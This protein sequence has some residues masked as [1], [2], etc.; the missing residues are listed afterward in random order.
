ML[1]TDFRGDCDQISWRLA[2][3]HGHQRY[4][5]PHVRAGCRCKAVR[6]HHKEFSSGCGYRDHRRAVGGAHCGIH[7][8]SNAYWRAGMRRRIADDG[9]S[10]VR[11]VG[12]RKGTL[13][14]AWTGLWHTCGRSWADIHGDDLHKRRWLVFRRN[15]CHS[16]CGGFG[17]LA[18]RI[19]T[20]LARASA[21]QRSAA[22]FCASVR[23]CLPYRAGIAG[24][25][26]P[27]AASTVPVAGVGCCWGR[28]ARGWL[29][30]NVQGS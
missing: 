30:P 29:G 8:C 15:Y 22:A 25:T 18:W 21:S 12:G 17:P 4:G 2:G 28:R 27:A 14:W 5:V 3:K 11:D 13:F 1:S 7:N 9:S 16:C 6:C 10:D 24:S 23:Y 19:R 20:A 26:G